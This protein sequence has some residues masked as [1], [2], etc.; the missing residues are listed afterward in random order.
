MTLMQC[1]TVICPRL[2]RDGGGDKVM[3]CDVLRMEDA[4]MDGDPHRWGKEEVQSIGINRAFT[5]GAKM[6]FSN[7]NHFYKR[8]NPLILN[9]STHIWQVNHMPHQLVLPCGQWLTCHVNLICQ[10]CKLRWNLNLLFCG[11]WFS[12][13]RFMLCNS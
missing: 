7:F 10:N 11:A 6:Y 9:K 13:F 1:S 8:M 5:N 4:V 12:F 2:L 3:W